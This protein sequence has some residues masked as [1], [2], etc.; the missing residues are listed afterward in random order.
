MPD[1]SPAFA[2][3]ANVL[4]LLLTRDMNRSAAVATLNS[5]GFSTREIAGLVGSTEGSVRAM[6][7]QSRKKAAGERPTKDSDG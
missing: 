4:A 3:I 2:R 5:C 1:E 6:L 7:S